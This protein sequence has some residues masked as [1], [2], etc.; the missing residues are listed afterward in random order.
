MTPHVLYHTYTRISWHFRPQQLCL[1]CVY[2]NFRSRQNRKEPC[3]RVDDIGTDGWT[4]LGC[5]RVLVRQRQR[6]SGP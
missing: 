4:E 3:P 5:G 6:Q 1:H 2:D